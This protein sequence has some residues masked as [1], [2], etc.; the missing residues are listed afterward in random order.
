M[1]PALSIII[2]T[3]VSGAGYGMLVWYGL[4]SAFY[5]TS[6]ER[7]VALVVLPFALLLLTAGLLSST[8]HLGR[9]ERAW[10]A[11][12]QWRTS[13]LS[14]EGIC[15]FAT[16]VPAGLLTLA[17]IVR[18]APGAIAVTLGLATAFASLVTIYCTA[19]IYASLKTVHQWCN[20]YVVPNYLALGLYSGALLL[21]AALHL[22]GHGSPNVDLI[23]VI[24][25][26]AAL[27]GKLSYWRFIA[28]T[29]HP[30]SPESATGLGQF[31]KVS[32]FEAPHTEENF[33]MREMG[34]TIAR[35][36]AEKLRM[37]SL[38]A[39]FAAPLTLMLIAVLTGG[40]TAAVVTIVAVLLAAIGVFLE[41]WL[42]FAEARHVVTLFYGARAA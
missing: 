21:S 33:L 26:L 10:R 40:V 30:S 32:L 7:V 42:F 6:G 16:Y 18:P 8:F 36:H 29:R 39:L 2:F 17:W 5:G 41:R 27:A 38:L 14:R 35:K 22:V 9:P 15:S 34:F 19:M 23:A 24:A 25:G 37:L 12:S 3:T 1:H 31:G 11:L 20:P 4:M 28:T 13:W